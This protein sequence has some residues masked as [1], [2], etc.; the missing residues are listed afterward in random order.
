MGGGGYIGGGDYESSL[1]SEVERIGSG[2][3]GFQGAKGNESDLQKSC[4]L[5]TFVTP[6]NSV[7][8]QVL[9]TIK[10][11]DELLIR[12]HAGSIVATDVS[13]NIA[14]AITAVE[15]AQLFACMEVG[16]RYVGIV[17]SINGGTCLVRIRHRR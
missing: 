4:P 1:S 11:G 15:L 10:I 13:G 3:A 8:P 16:Y 12:E 14:G 9:S 6:L 7:D 2:D 17:E 5:L